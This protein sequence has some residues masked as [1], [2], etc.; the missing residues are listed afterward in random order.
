MSSS[1]LL[2]SVDAAL[3]RRAFLWKLSLMGS[4]LLLGVFGTRRLHAGVPVKCCDL[5]FSAQLNQWNPAGCA[6]V[7]CWACPHC[8]CWNYRCY[9]CVTVPGDYACSWVPGAE[10]SPDCALISRSGIVKLVRTPN[11]QN[12]C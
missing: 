9:E 6:G 2:E 7:W 12:S 3:R 10:W 11:C 4:A 1:K 8:D 5:C